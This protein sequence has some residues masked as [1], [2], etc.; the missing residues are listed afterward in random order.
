MA[1]KSLILV[2]T[3]KFLTGISTLNP[4][5]HCDSYVRKPKPSTQNPQNPH[6]LH[7]KPYKG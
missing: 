7:P 4:K 1:V 3:I 6:I 5:P 2:M